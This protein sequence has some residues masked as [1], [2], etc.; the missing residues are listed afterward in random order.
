MAFSDTLSKM[1]YNKY[2]LEGVL[3]MRGIRN[4]K[5]YTTCKALNFLG[6]LF[7]MWLLVYPE[8]YGLV[9]AAN[10]ITPIWAICVY[11]LN[12]D[13][14]RFYADKGG[15]KIHVMFAFIFPALILTMN[16]LKKFN[17]LYNNYLWIILA[18]LTLL[19][20]LII[21]FTARAYIEEKWLPLLIFI[22]LG[23]YFHGAVILTNCVYDTS[24]PKLYTSTIID[25]SV[26]SGKTTLYYLTLSPFGPIKE[27]HEIVVRERLY[28]SSYKGG[29]VNIYL[30]DGLWHI[31]WINANK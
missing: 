15:N 18:S 11:I 2:Q 7:S 19:F 22:F 3:K 4:Q 13:I 8:P 28:E 5:L 26:R 9:L 30:N 10:I 12:S 29:T 27:N 1:L 6:I 20:T 24:S 23:F 25:K 21:S 14:V 16:S 31:K 17:I